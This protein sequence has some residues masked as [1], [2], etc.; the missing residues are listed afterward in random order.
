MRAALVVAVLFAILGAMPAGA[1]E[2]EAHHVVPFRA[3][4][5]P[6]SALDVPL[7]FEEGPLEAGWVFL[8]VAE[9]ESNGTA[10][11][12]EL[13]LGTTAVETWTLPASGEARFFA[14]LPET[15]AYGVHL[16]NPSP[17]DWI[18]VRFYFDQSCNC[19]GKIIPG[20]FARALVVF[21]F[22]FQS[23]DT[24]DAAFNE[25]A[26]IR[27]RVTLATRSGPG[28][29]WPEAY[30]PI[31]TSE[32]AVR[33]QVSEQAGP[34]LL[35]QFHFVPAVTATYYFFVENKSYTG[36]DSGPD[37][38]GVAPYIEITPASF[39]WSFVLIGAAAGLVIVGFLY[40]RLR[41]RR[42]EPQGKPLSRRRNPRGR[43]GPGP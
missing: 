25:P 14:L 21:S 43:R 33:V 37:S 6:E 22:E 34:V 18:Q 29:I 9:V 11:T 2:G 10:G 32:N 7:T 41:D 24:I 1:H 39:P 4:L 26:A 42:K 5:E 12:M 20:G 38:Y 28:A 36:N 13:R 19:L 40:I 8:L 27:T 30:T 35:H 3:V 23:G 31:K 17:S 15:G 16:Q